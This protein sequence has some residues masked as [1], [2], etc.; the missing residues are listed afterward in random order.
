MACTLARRMTRLALLGLT[1]ALGASAVQAQAPMPLLRVIGGPAASNTFRLHERQFWGAE[2]AQ[3]SGGRYAAVLQSIDAIGGNDL[4]MLALVQSGTL[5]IAAIPVPDVSLWMPSLHVIDLAGLSPDA[6]RL[7]EDLALIR[8]GLAAHLREGHEVE[9]LAMMTYAPRVLYCRAPVDALD[10]LQGLRIGPANVSQSDLLSALGAQPLSMPMEGAIRDLRHGQLDCVL[11]SAPEAV[12]R[13]L[14]R[15]ARAVYDLPLSWGT[16]LLAANSQAWRSLPQDLR[17]DLE[18][19]FPAFEARVH[20][21]ALDDHR[22][23]LACST[24]R[25]P[26]A[27]GVLPGKLQWS[28]ASPQDLQRSQKL[29]RDAVLPAWL[30]RCPQPCVGFWNSGIGAA[31]GWRVGGTP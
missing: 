5:P 31:R 19:R 9:L 10:K 3:A 17:A 1:W 25:G 20:Q 24:G 15:I 21:Q 27:D 7:Q 28:Q 22:Q 2:L 13:G 26:C 23:A 14:H 6:K 29:F 12:Y 30:A 11:S 16:R 4:E 8:P 18:R